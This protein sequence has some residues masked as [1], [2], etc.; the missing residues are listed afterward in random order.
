MIARYPAVGISIAKVYVPAGDCRAGRIGA[1]EIPSHRIAQ[2][3]RIWG[4]RQDAN[5][6][7]ADIHNCVA[8]NVAAIG[9]E[10]ADF[11]QDSSPA[12]T[13][14]SRFDFVGY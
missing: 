4:Q 5:R 13:L 11:A 3:N 7:F 9:P 10:F 1:G 14:V 2:A 6:L 8:V 12:D